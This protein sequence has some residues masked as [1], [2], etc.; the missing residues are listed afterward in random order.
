METL[1]ETL[2]KAIDSVKGPFTLIAFLAVVALAFF[3]FEVKNGSL[4]RSLPHLFED[5]L[6]RENFYRLSRLLISGCL[7]IFL[8]LGVLS[9]LLMFGAIKASDADAGSQE[10]TAVS[11]TEVALAAE[12]PT[13][14]PEAPSDDGTAEGPEEPAGDGEEGEVEGDPSTAEMQCPIEPAG[15]GE[16]LPGPLELI[17]VTTIDSI[18]IIATWPYA[19][20]IRNTEIA[21]SRDGSILISA[22]ED[23]SIELW[24]VVDG[25]RLDRY[26]V[27]QAQILDIAVATAESD[28]Q[29]FA[30]ASSDSTARVWI[31]DEHIARAFEQ[32]MKRDDRGMNAVA[33]SPDGEF[34]VTGDQTNRISLWN[35]ASRSLLDDEVW[36][37]PET[38]QEGRFEV[39]AVGF[40][41]DGRRVA[42]T[43][44]DGTIQ[45]WNISRGETPQSSPVLRRE[46]EIDPRSPFDLSGMSFSPSDANV[47]VTSY[48]LGPIRFWNVQ[49]RDVLGEIRPVDP[50]EQVEYSIDGRFLAGVTEAGIVYFW[51]LDGSELRILDLLDRGRGMAFSPDQKYMALGTESGIEIYGVDPC[52]N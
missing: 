20:Q 18:Q 19:S 52:S 26:S 4:I 9:L 1:F 39:T 30:T 6:T 36:L 32:V 10:P 17:S 51:G 13:M 31:L 14:P 29:L 33:F 40:S 21:F 37:D 16:P 22:L 46:F 7:A 35:V 45:F 44:S 34:I 41:P 24:S 49:A 11:P 27:H 5:R 8:V 48:A 3:Y 28:L 2:L 42:A 47:V 12:E 23:G 38:Q 43:S 15:E 25:R 50:V